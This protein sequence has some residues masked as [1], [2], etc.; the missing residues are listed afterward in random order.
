MTWL[1]PIHK[2]LD[3]AL[4]PATF[5]FRDDDAGWRDDCLFTLLDLFNRYS[6]PIDL[7]V[8]PAELTP[9]LANE[10]RDRSEASPRLLDFHQHGWAHL[11]H[12]SQGRKCEFGPARSKSEQY[13]DLE[14]GKQKMAELLDCPGHIFTPPWNRCSATTVECLTELG[15]RV[16]SR[17]LTATPLALNGLAQLPVNIDWFAKRKGERVSVA[18]LGKLIADAVAEGSNVGIMLHHAVIDD[19][20]IER[21][22]ELLEVLSAH[23]NANCLQMKTVSHGTSADVVNVAVFER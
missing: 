5:F 23:T 21:V 11:N 9:Q 6:V 14:V 18:C 10:L 17:D 3:G 13:L 4:K 16:L 8:I 20:E 22:G 19:N 15:F 12:E 7:A 1:D 2:A